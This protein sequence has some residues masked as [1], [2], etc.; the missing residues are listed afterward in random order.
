MLKEELSLVTEQDVRKNQGTI[1]AISF[2]STAP[3]RDSPIL[4]NGW[5]ESFD[6]D[7]HL[8]PESDKIRVYATTKPLVCRQASGQAID[9]YGPTD[10][11][12]STYAAVL[13]EHVNRAITRACQQFTQVDSK[14]IKCQ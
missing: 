14:I 11:Q 8:Y 2:R 10:A 1:S 12:K 5:R 13:N 3:L 6:F 7:L 4:K 9:Y